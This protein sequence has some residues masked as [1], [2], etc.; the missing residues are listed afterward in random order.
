MALHHAG[1]EVCDGAFDCAVTALLA[2][3][4]RSAPS[5]SSMTVRETQNSRH[6]VPVFS[7]ITVTRVRPGK[8][9]VPPPSPALPAGRDVTLQIEPAAAG[10]HSPNPSEGVKQNTK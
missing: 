4:N 8:R 6:G 7:S 3:H 9:M 2:A 10:T 1:F 5:T